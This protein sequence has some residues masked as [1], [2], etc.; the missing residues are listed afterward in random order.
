MAAH[1]LWICACITVDDAPTWLIYDTLSGELR[2]LRVLD[3]VDVQNVVGA[4]L[5]A[6]GHADPADV[7][8]WLHGSAPDPW[9]TVGSGSGD[10]EVLEHL[11][12]KIRSSSR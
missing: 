1:A 9:S 11:R 7:L 6:G 10:T 2:W 4:Q 3:G 12:S 8:T 5:S